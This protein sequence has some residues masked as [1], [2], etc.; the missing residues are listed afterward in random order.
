MTLLVTRQYLDYLDAFSSFYA[1]DLL[2]KLLISLS[3]KENTKQGRALAPYDLNPPQDTA[4]TWSNTEP[5]LS[6]KVLVI[7]LKS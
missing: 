4:L 3:P 6:T 2:E 7:S 5:R 1:Y